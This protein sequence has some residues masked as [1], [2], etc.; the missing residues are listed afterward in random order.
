PP[1]EPPRSDHRQ[2][3][4]FRL[5]AIFL[6][7]DQQLRDAR[8]MKRWLHSPQT[9]QPNRERIDDAAQS[10]RSNAKSA[11]AAVVSR[12]FQL[13]EGGNAERIMNLPRQPRTNA[14]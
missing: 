8:L 4:L 12:A 13:L 10:L 1:I 6:I 7:D 3:T 5:A 9:G 14:R 11:Q 2:P